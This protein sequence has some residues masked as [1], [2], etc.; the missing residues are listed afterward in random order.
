MK[1]NIGSYD[2]KKDGWTNV[3]IDPAAKP[4]V[5]ASAT[6]LPYG[7]GVVEEIYC[8]HMLE[9]LDKYEAR[10]ALNEFWRVLAPNGQL[11]IVVPDIMR[12]AE[13]YALRK[14]D[15]SWMERIAFGGIEEREAQAHKQ[16]YCEDKLKTDLTN[17]GFSQLRGFTYSNEYPVSVIVG[18]QVGLSCKKPQRL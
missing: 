10:K 2:V 1:L 7:D 16:L 13:M 12:G 11:H 15:M 5:I 8:G 9:H 3:D 18:W 14:I 6:E 4:D 17:A